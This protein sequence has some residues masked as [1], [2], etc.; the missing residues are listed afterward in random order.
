V[1][2]IFT[3]RAHIGA[4]EKEEKRRDFQQFLHFLQQ[5]LLAISSAL[6]VSPGLE[7]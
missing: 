4:E 3:C 7:Y 1:V 6:K 2:K 5:C